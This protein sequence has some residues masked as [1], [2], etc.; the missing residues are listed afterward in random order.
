MISS[1]NIAKQG[2]RINPHN[3]FKVAV[4]ELSAGIPRWLSEALGDKFFLQ[5]KNL[6]YSNAELYYYE[7]PDGFEGRS[8]LKIGNINEFRR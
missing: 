3:P 4:H 5:Y 2:A 6:Y 8:I 7:C 1:R